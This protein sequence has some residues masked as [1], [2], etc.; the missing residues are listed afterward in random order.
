M[1]DSIPNLIK[2][3]YLTYR[4]TIIMY[5]FYTTYINVDLEHYDLFHVKV[6]KGGICILNALPASN[7]V[8]HLLITFS[9]SSLT[10]KA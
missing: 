3:V 6:G 1:R 8:R 4:W 10:D 7:N 2:V 5:L 9:N